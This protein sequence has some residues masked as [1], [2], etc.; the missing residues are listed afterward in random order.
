M[1][2]CCIKLFSLFSK[3]ENKRENE[4]LLASD[5]L[6]VP[7]DNIVTGQ[8]HTILPRLEAETSDC[9]GT[10]TPL[11]FRFGSPIM[12]EP[13]DGVES[14]KHITKQSTTESYQDKRS[15][16]QEIPRKVESDEEGYGSSFEAVASASKNLRARKESRDQETLFEQS[17]KENYEA[18]VQVA[19]ASIQ[20]AEKSKKKEDESENFA[21]DVDYYSI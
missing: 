15:D 3:R 13:S 21:A 17:T 19:L 11:S 20:D 4:P 1:G 6:L 5:P 18:E 8:R 7:V 16:R 2:N 10:S 14:E 12:L 9:Q